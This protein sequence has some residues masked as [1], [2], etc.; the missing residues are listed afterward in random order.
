MAANAVA[1]CQAAVILVDPNSRNYPAESSLRAA[2]QLTSA[3]ARL[4]ARLATGDSLETIAGQ[5]GIAKE[6]ARNQ[7]KSIFAKIGIHRRAELVAVLAS[8]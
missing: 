7:L 1:D 6:T 2:F 4:A 5:L 3:E 8:F